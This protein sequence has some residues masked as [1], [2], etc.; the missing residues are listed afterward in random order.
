[1]KLIKSLRSPV[2]FQPL[3]QEL[4]PIIKYLNKRVLNAGCG[5]RDLSSFLL[6]NGATYVENCDISSSIPNAVICDL[7]KIPRES[8][9]YDSI[10]CNAV[11]E[12]VQFPD[13]VIKELHRVLKPSGFLVLGVPFLQPYHPCPTDFQRFTKD[14]LLEIARLHD[15]EVV[16]FL[17]VHSIAQTVSWIVWEYLLEKKNQIMKLILWVPF[18]LWTRIYQTTDF[19][20][21]NHANTYQI[22]LRKK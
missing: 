18:Y 9:T 16:E 14:G 12:H 19:S 2:K 15:F 8:N 7:T 5:E 1:M 10:L 11:L 3:E 21:I 6:N 17:P 13:L 20:L 22:V 4:M